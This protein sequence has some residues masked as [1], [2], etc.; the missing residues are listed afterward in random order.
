MQSTIEKPNGATVKVTVEASASEVKPAVDRA[1]AQIGRSVKIPGFRPGKV[2]R[3]VLEKR[4]GSDYLKDQVVQQ[5]VPELLG[6][7]VDE[8]EIVTIGQPRI[9]VTSYELDGDL[10]FEA[11]LDVRPEIPEPN[12]ELLNV[13]VPPTEATEEE[14]NDQLSRIAD[15]FAT[16]EPVDRPIATGDLV[17][18]DIKITVDGAEP[19]PLQSAD[20]L[21]EVGQGQPL[22]ELDDELRT[23]S[24]GDPVSFN[25]TLPEGFGEWSGKQAV[26]DVTI[27]EVSQ[28][29]VPA[30]DDN[31]AS[32]ASEFD[33][34]DEL[35]ADISKKITDIKKAQADGMIRSEL[36]NQAV[37]DTDFAVPESYVVREM[38]YRLQRFEQE[39]GQAGMSLQDYLSQNNFTEEQVE[40]DLRSQAERNVRAQLILEQIAKNQEIQVSEEELTQELGD[41]AQAARLTEA[42]AKA[43]FS[44]RDQIVAIAGDI[45]RRKALSYLVERSGYG[46]ADAGTDAEAQSD[47]EEE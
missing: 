38:A 32:D 33:T 9:E 41:R 39:L 11:T 15:R 26:L 20:Q 5:A 8:H 44:D 36:L 22:P 3:A 24:A 46:P 19:E 30:L 1:V 10:V 42:Q 28:K 14:V 6:K 45:V 18:L 2:P 43:L 31:F 4:V 37:N 47:D 21:Y 25:A 16:L 13:D 34:L 29:I 40:S 12:Y 7:A 17:R 23:R 35:R 27:K